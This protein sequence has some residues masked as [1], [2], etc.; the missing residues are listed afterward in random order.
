MRVAFDN[1]ATVIATILR[2]VKGAQE[3]IIDRTP[4]LRMI[5]TANPSNIERLGESEN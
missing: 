5:P 1:A 2:F 3:I 4:L